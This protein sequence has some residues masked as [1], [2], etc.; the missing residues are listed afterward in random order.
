MAAVLE[1]TTDGFTDGVDRGGGKLVGVQADQLQVLS[2]TN[3]VAQFF[4]LQIGGPQG[5]CFCRE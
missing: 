3:Q 4:E 1:P 2:K 5:V